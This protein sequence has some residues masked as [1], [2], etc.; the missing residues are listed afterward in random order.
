MESLVL[1]KVTKKYNDV[2][3]VS[4]VYAKINRNEFVTIV[5]PSGCGK[6]T[7]LRMIAGFVEPS[8]G[9]I[10]LDGEELAN[11]MYKRFVPPEKRGIGMVFQSYAVWPHM[12]VF[13][14]VAYPLKIRKMKK[15]DIV[16]KTREILRIVHLSDYEKRFPHELS[17]GQQQRVA[18]A[19]ALVM[20]PRLLL[21]DEPLSNLDAALREQ[22]RVEIKEIQRKLGVT[23]INVTHDQIEAMTMSD[24]VIV[25]DQGKVVQIGSPQE[26]YNRPANS[27]VAKFIGSANILPCEW[28]GPVSPIKMKI[29]V[30]GTELEVPAVKTKQ[31]RGLVA[32]RPHHIKPDPNSKLR[33]KIVNKLYKGDRVEYWLQIENEKICMVTD[34]G[35]THDFSND[36]EIGISVQHGVWLEH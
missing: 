25:M 31:K 24:K 5:G 22:M 8:D 11:A 35:E 32:I 6:T 9:T 33:G 18:L 34:A 17:G 30:F 13:D 3:V 16:E 28:L 23:I 20:E 12:N 2:T 1:E 14:N 27:F 4:D 7:T 26:I 10:T 29:G 21:L 15:W 36:D 19:R